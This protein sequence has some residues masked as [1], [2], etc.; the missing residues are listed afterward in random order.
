MPRL[1]TSERT[2]RTI[3][4]PAASGTAL[5]T[6]SMPGAGGLRRAPRP[7]VPAIGRQPPR[8]GEIADQVTVLTPIGSETVTGP[9]IVGSACRASCAISRRPSSERIG[10]TTSKS[11]WPVGPSRERERAQPEHGRALVEQ[12]L[13]VEHRDVDREHPAPR[14]QSHR[15]LLD[16][17]GASEEDLEVVEGRGVG[18]SEGAAHLPS[19]LQPMTD[20]LAGLLAALDLTDTGAR[21]SEDIFTGPSQWTA[22]RSRLR[23]AGARAVAGGRHPHRRPRIASCTRCTAT[24][25]GRATPSSRSPSRST[26]ST[27]AARSRPGARRR[28]RTA[29]RS[30]R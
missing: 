2:R 30:C 4:S 20:P 27:T 1:H 6:S 16:A 15:A 19:K 3:C 17:C 9:E 21:T 5:A 7:S 23:R 10:T 8:G 18:E 25:C 24:S 26:A 28:T 12:A 29:S 22:G 11:S 13:R 14:D